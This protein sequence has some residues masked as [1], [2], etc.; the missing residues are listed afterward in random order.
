[1]K[2]TTLLDLVDKYPFTED[3]IRKFDGVA[4]CCL[5]C[6]HLFDTIEQIEVE[7]GINLNELVNNLINT[8]DLKSK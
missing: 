6:T 1:M 2:N 5:L 7:R 3:I 4:G 8:I